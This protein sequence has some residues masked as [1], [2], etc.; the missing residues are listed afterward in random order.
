MSGSENQKIEL[1]EGRKFDIG[2]VGLWY[3]SNYGS[4]MTYFALYQTLEKMGYS[5]LMIDKLYRGNRDYEVEAKTHARD[6]AI[7]HYKNIA[8][9]LKAEEMGLLNQYCDTFLIG[10][11]QVWNY[12]IAKNLGYNNYFD[13]VADDKK[14]LSYASSFGHSISF[15]PL[16]EISDI[17]KLLHRF[18]AISVREESGVQVLRN[19]FGLEGTQVVDPVFL[20]DSEE[21]NL[22]LEEATV[23]ENE[24]YL[25]AYILDPTP[26]IREALQYVADKK[27]LK[28]INILDG[29]GDFKKN[30]ETLNLPNIVEKLNTPNWLWYFKNAEF[31][32]TDSCHGASFSLI[33]NRPFITIANKKRGISRFESLFDMFRI[34]NRLIFD[35]SLIMKE[36][37]L[38][39]DIGYER[40]S[41]ILKMERKR[42]LRWLTDAL[43]SKKKI[44]TNINCVVSK[45]CC[46]CGACYNTCPVDA[47]QMKYDREGI[48][49]PNV[50]ANK[51]IN[52]KKCMNA[53][54]SLHPDL[55]N[56]TMP[57]SYAAY[58]GDDIRAKSSSGGIFSLVADKVLKEGGA[59]CGA[60]FDDKFELSQEVIRSEDDLP[61][62]RGSK[63]I[64]SDTKK[65]YSEIKVVLEEEKPALYV[66]CPCQIAGLKS[67]L[68]KKYDKLFT[69]DLLCH[70]GPSPKAF[71]KYLDEVH[72]GKEIA[73]VGFRD[74]DYYGWSTEMTV[75][76]KNGSIYRKLR[77]E[78]P[79]YRA[80]LPCLSVRPHC[81]VCNYAR[82]PRQGDFTL[83][84]FW[85]VAKLNPELTDGKGTSILVA[86][87]P[88]AEEMIDK[89]KDELKLLE[90]VDTEYILTHGQPFGRPFKNN[91]RR[92]RFLRM[93]ENNSFE[94]SL[95]CCAKN[96][97]DFGLYGMNADSYGDILS[98]YALYQSISKM[99]YSLLMLKRPK[100]LEQKIT[101]LKYRLMNFANRYYPA[102]S[103]QDRLGKL[104]L[105]NDTCNNFILGE[106]QVWESKNGTFFGFA[107]ENKQVV[108]YGEG[109]KLIGQT[110]KRVID[111]VFLPEQSVYESLVEKSQL[112]MN[113]PY[114]A[115][116]F[117][118]VEHGLKEKINGYAEKKKYEIVDL[119]EDMQV[120]DWLKY[121]K[122]AKTFI[123][124]QRDGIDFAIIFNTPVLI[125]ESKASDELDQFI[126]EFKLD[127]R[128]W[129]QGNSLELSINIITDLGY[130]QVDK[131]LEDGR[132]EALQWLDKILAKIVKNVE[133]AKN[134]IVRR[135][136]RKILRFIKNRMPEGLKSKLYPVIKKN[137]FFKKHIKPL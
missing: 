129:K 70:G 63:Y 38:L 131:I 137:I 60:A 114:I 4:V 84:D 8:P 46:G 98:Y 108:A 109:A 99:G 40:I 61:K 2:L 26:E 74:K 21:Y 123:T 41:D 11:D 126:Q 110:P 5:V 54:P 42:S 93:L 79:F 124:D 85:G 47:I 10:S 64:Q 20:L 7:K 65:T 92:Y 24:K 134:S 19:E 82:L 90:K 119:S 112:I 96:E 50:D 116:Y 28:L 53:C 87:S 77:S 81:Q 128:I 45:E 6:F 59:V 89:I 33:F 58:G 72:N 16:E 56:S 118:K 34:R 3:G 78:D 14:K 117:D 95:E 43:E 39:E 29:R 27:Q 48:L 25:L 44:D 9:S 101:P 62:L 91:A 97:F 113:K 68:G 55:T 13:Y 52:C 132:Q 23:Q 122:Y 51:C 75:K 35:V 121:V 18:D 100:E 105:V 71:Q 73:Y 88:Q 130:G 120:E 107:K 1:L 31:V 106:N 12:G 135:G 80:F 133:R 111:A 32:I 76:Y 83:G 102:V 104:Q 30:K 115:I 94:K 37:A 125:P 36:D 69:I 67:F 22:I 66:G 49:Y 86:N 136:V 57:N 127:K 15:T 17:T 103:S